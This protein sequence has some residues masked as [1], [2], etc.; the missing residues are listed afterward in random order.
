MNGS[1][2]MNIGKYQIYLDLSFNK[3]LYLIFLLVFGLGSLLLGPPATDRIPARHELREVSGVGVRQV[4]KRSG[5]AYVFE[6]FSEN[7]SNSEKIS[8]LVPL[9]QFDPSLEAGAIKLLYLPDNIK[10]SI[11]INIFEKNRTM[12]VWVVKVGE[13]EIL[14]YERSVTV[15]RNEMQV[16]KEFKVVGLICLMLIPALTV[17]VRGR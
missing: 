6:K 12:K 17:R 9:Y 5:T 1:Y 11:K 7:E 4:T 14:S 2:M 8:W 10:N 16:A 13:K 15:F 3:A